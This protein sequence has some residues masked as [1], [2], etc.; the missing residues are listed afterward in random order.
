MTCSCHVSSLDLVIIDEILQMY[1][2]Q[3]R[4]GYT[5][6]LGFQE[7]CEMNCFDGKKG[8]VRVYIIS[9]LQTGWW[10]KG[11]NILR[12]FSILKMSI[13]NCPLPGCFCSLHLQSFLKC[14]PMVTPLQHLATGGDTNVDLR[15]HL[16]W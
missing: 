16:C 7:F 12:L 9:T 8:G 14:Q 13:L 15:P 1:M 6:Y 11:R 5:I 4:L 3:V 2:R 10:L